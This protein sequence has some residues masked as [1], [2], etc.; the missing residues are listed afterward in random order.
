MYE[1]ANEI[2][3]KLS[4]K[5]LWTFKR[6]KYVKESTSRASLVSSHHGSIGWS[7]SGSEGT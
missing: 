7:W 5:V 1:M 2:L 6:K 3:K 4:E